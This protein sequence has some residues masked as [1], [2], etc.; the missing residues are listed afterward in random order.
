MS[1]QFADRFC[2]RF[3]RWINKYVSRKREHRDEIN[4][5]H[6]TRDATIN[7]Y[8]E[9]CQQ[10]TTTLAQFGIHAEVTTTFDTQRITLY[11]DIKHEHTKLPYK[12]RRDIASNTVSAFN[13]HLNSDGY[14]Q[15]IKTYATDIENIQHQIEK[16]R[17]INTNLPTLFTDSY[18]RQSL[19]MLLDKST[20]FDD[21][22]LVMRS[23]H[24][25]Y[26]D[27]GENFDI[28]LSDTLRSPHPI[29]LNWFIS[30][31][32]AKHRDLSLLAWAYSVPDP[33][34]Q[35]PYHQL[36]DFIVDELLIHSIVQ[37][38]TIQ[39][40]TWDTLFG[41]QYIT[42]PTLRP[43][44]LITDERRR[45]RP[46]D[47]L[48]LD[49]FTFSYVYL[50]NEYSLNSGSLG[51]D[52]LLFDQHQGDF[53]LVV[54]DG[55]S[56]SCLSDA[57][58]RNVAQSL[59]HVWQL[60]RHKVCDVSGLNDLLHRAFCVAK[61][62]SNY[63]VASFLSNPPEHYSSTTISILNKRNEDGGSQSIFACAFSFD[64]KVY[65]IWM[66]NTAII[67][68]GDV[69]GDVLSYNDER[70]QDD[71]IRFSSKAING[72]RGDYHMQIFDD[73]LT[74]NTK[75]RI[76]IH[77]DALEEYPDREETL[78]TAPLERPSGRPLNADDVK[79]EQCIRI[80]DTT[81]VELFYERQ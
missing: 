11:D 7:T 40:H 72:L 73:F 81:I 12:Q 74:A 1:N 13:T 49:N 8:R 52:V 56:Q 24:A 54:C 9:A 37:E 79:L 10:L 17:A 42:Q 30:R 39:T 69:Q 60:L 36:L 44:P 33:T 76:V 51:E 6:E 15:T 35:Q 22:L 67:M 20:Q 66:G 48:S 29:M 59:H 18:F 78:Y 19:F 23:L 68:Q 71:S 25:V 21:A 62:Q 34:I 47:R 50:P 26:H 27:Y 61:H 31:Y 55:V 43:S 46:K 77:S 70:F 63:D 41:T 32:Y 57:A 2:N 45:N 65:T 3:K 28:V 14:E 80:D 58:A 5:R 75:W 38:S 53:F 64:G 16:V 4:V